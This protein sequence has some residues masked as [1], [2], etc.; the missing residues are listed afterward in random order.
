V[1][2]R[3]ARLERS[4]TVQE[5]PTQVE[6]ALDGASPAE[7]LLFNDGELRNVDLV[8]KGVG[9]SS[10]P[11]A[12]LHE[13]EARVIETTGVL[14]HARRQRHL[15]DCPGHLLGRSG[16]RG[17]DPEAQR[18]VVD[19]ALEQVSHDLAAR[20][21]RDGG[22]GEHATKVLARQDRLLQRREFASHRGERGRLQR[23]QQGRGVSFE[24]REHDQRF[25]SLCASALRAETASR[26]RSSWAF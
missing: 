3:Q 9:E 19:L 21:A 6:V 20:V 4:V 17:V 10:D 25:D 18:R 12:G 23:T 7:E 5:E 11:P 24:L 8:E 14:E 16:A 22:V 2:G 13:A 15:V 1:T 26:M